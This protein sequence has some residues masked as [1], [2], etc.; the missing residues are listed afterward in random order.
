MLTSRALTR[1]KVDHSIA[2]EPH[3]YTEYENALDR[4]NLREYAKLLT[5]PFS[6][7][8]QGSGRARNWCWDH[9]I[10]IGAEKH[11]LMDDNISSFLRLHKNRRIRVESGVIFRIAEDFV[12][13]Y[14]N[15][16]VAGLNY[17]CFAKESR[18]LPPYDANRRIFSCL[19]ID[20]TGKH[21]WRGKYNEDVDLSLRILKDGDC[22]IQFNIFLQD[23]MGT[24]KIKGG[25]TEELYGEGT[26]EKSQMIV[27]MH[28]DVA[29]VK[30]IFGRW[31]HKVD[32]SSFANNKLRLK[33]NVDLSKLPKVDNYGLKLVEDWKYDG[34]V[35]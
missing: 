16:P 32:Y 26:L 14:E 24:Q 23:K 2:I 22:T 3:E 21:R 29:E 27:D 31:H 7:H 6:N 10:S 34:I 20:N 5:L 25:N 4:F 11:W 30:W 12:D 13:R 8:G 1:M 18:P 17:V 28:P 19:L 9:S 35:K 33:P 15:V